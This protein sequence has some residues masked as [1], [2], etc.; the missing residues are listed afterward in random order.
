VKR[1]VGRELLPGADHEGCVLREKVRV[2]RRVVLEFPDHR[3]GRGQR[4]GP[5]EGLEVGLGVRFS[6]AA[7][8][9]QERVADRPVVAEE[10]APAQSIPLEGMDVLDRDRSHRG[11]A[12]VKQED[13][14]VG[15]RFQ[16]VTLPA[17]ACAS[18]PNELPV[19]LND[20]AP[21]IR[22][23]EVAWAPVEFVAGVL[24]LS[25]AQ[26]GFDQ[27]LSSD[28]SGGKNHPAHSSGLPPSLS[29][30]TP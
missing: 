1:V 8:R 9:P 30:Y 18:H 7:G 15:Q 25:H 22:M 17:R 4:V 12:G 23:L 10:P 14:A 20:R 27:P 19:I 29:D 24:A 2:E 13:A 5:D 28:S 6:L 26:E 3:G 21:T 11:A 16:A